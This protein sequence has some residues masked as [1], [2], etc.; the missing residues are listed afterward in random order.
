MRL[1]QK[2]KILKVLSFE[3]INYKSFKES[4][5]KETVFIIKFYKL[6]KYD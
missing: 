1:Y 6:N 5:P 2:R 3:Y 4:T